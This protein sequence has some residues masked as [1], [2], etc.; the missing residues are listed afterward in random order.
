MAE[1]KIGFYI[2]IDGNEII[3]QIIEHSTNR[4][5]FD[6]ERDLAI[7][8]TKQLNTFYVENDILKKSWQDLERLQ[9]EDVRQLSYKL[10]ENLASTGWLHS[11]D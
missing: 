7:Q 6:Q 5:R 4:N 3:H 8:I 2:D 11:T 10:R 9:Q 1:I